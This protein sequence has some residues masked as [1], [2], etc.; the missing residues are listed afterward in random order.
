MGS[1][2][3]LQTAARG[4]RARHLRVRLGARR[5]AHPAIQITSSPNKVGELFPHQAFGLASPWAQRSWG[6]PGDGRILVLSLP[7]ASVGAF[8][9]VY[10]VLF[11][12]CHFKIR[13]VHLTIT[14]MSSFFYI[15]PLWLCSL[16]ALSSPTRAQ[17]WAPQEK[18]RILTAR[19]PGSPTCL[20]SYRLGC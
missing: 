5:P 2:Q 14:Q 10:N 9:L 1:R 8:H 7:V 16:R 12:C 11:S 18:R 19:P 6:N 17:T 13:R 4:Q 20:T 3:G 15:S